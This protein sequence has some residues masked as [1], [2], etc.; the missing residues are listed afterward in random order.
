MI[1]EPDPE[2]DVLLREER[3]AFERG[4]IG[5]VGVHID[6]DVHIKD[7]D[8]VLTSPGAWGIEDDVDTVVLDQIINEEWSALRAV[9]KTVGV[10]TDKLPLEIEREWIEWRT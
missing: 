3:A 7:T 4:E 8:Q 5:F 1:I 2:P 10:P 9:L 6:A